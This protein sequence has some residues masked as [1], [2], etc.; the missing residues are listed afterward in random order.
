MC[1]TQAFATAL[2]LGL[3]LGQPDAFGAG[4][5]PFRICFAFQN[6]DPSR[7]Y[8]WFPILAHFQYLV[9]AS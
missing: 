8:L 7:F 2:Q 3:C 6:R 4:T 5:F 9:Q 1:S